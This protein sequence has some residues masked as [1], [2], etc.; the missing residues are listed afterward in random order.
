MCWTGEA[1]SGEWPVAEPPLLLRTRRFLPILGIGFCANGIVNGT[2]AS[3]G[4]QYHLPASVLKPYFSVVGDL[5]GLSLTLLQLTMQLPVG[6]VVTCVIFTIAAAAP[7]VL[8]LF[9]RHFRHPATGGT[10]Y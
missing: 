3:A 9:M 2:A 6:L 7:L 10:R 1:Y 5:P 4:R 8:S